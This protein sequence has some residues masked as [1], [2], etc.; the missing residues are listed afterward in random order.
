MP[1][2]PGRNMIMPINNS[3]Y[4]CHT[5]ENQN[6]TWVEVVTTT[7][8]SQQVSEKR[9]AEEANWTRVDVQQRRPETKSKLSAGQISKRWAEEGHVGMKTAAQHGLRF[10]A[11]KKE[12]AKMLFVSVWGSNLWWSTF[13]PNLGGLRPPV[14][15]GESIDLC[16]PGFYFHSATSLSSIQPR[17]VWAAVINM[18]ICASRGRRL[19]EPDSKQIKGRSFFSS[20]WDVFGPANDDHQLAVS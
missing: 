15:A 10:K 17:V 14:N 11:V 5:R 12:E 20:T 4:V 2:G 19:E 1:K 16:L 13:F 6:R 9:Q 8:G 3:M 7:N 18:C